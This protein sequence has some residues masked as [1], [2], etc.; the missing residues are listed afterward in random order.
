SLFPARQELIQEYLDGKL[1]ILPTLQ[2]DR[3]PTFTEKVKMQFGDK[4][5]PPKLSFARSPELLDTLWGEYFATGDYQPI[6]RIITLLPWSKDKDSVDRLTVGSMAKVTL[7]SNAS[8]YPDLLALLKDMRSYQEPATAKAMA[9]IIEAAETLQGPAIR[10]QALEAIEEL[11]RKGP[12]YRR[13]VAMWGQVGQGVLALGCI[14]AAAASMA[15]LG[16]PCV[17]GGAATSAALNYWSQ[18]Q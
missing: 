3:E 6:W 9:E 15:V 17:V 10:K 2:L 12:N 11:K 1:P 7:V 4:P 16:V 5:P 8:R 13:D 14:A 18:K